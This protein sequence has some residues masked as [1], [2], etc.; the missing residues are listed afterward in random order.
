ML[1]N[2]P[3]VETAINAIKDKKGNGITVI[4]LS[5]IPSSSADY[6][7]ICEGRS[8]S[9]VD[10]IADNVREEVQKQLSRKPYNY[11]GYRNSQWIIIDYGEVMVHV[12]LP[13]FRK[14]YNLE[15]LWGDGQLIN[16]PDED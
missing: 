11:D 6:F 10:A 4:D 8:T 1:Y 14:L 16:I 15:E 12:F 9:Q 7:V 5:K 13:D 2:S 3:V